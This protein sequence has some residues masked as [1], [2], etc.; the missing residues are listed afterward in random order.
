MI[1]KDD[2]T[3]KTE[4]VTESGDLEWVIPEEDEYTHLGLL[5][6]NGAIL[7]E[8]VYDLEKGTHTV[9]WTPEEVE[10]P[11]YL[12]TFHRLDRAKAY[13]DKRERDNREQYASYNY[14]SD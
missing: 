8:I 14:T 10:E 1:G 2:D 3:I 6:L 13:I 7:Y 12:W 9:W 11:V 5:R 4:V